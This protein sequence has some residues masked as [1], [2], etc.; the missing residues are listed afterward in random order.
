MVLLATTGMRPARGELPTSR[1]PSQ[2]LAQEL[3]RHLRVRG[4]PGLERRAVIHLSRAADRAGG[5]GSVVDP[6]TADRFRVVARAD[7][8]SGRGLARD[9]RARVRGARL[10][11]SMFSSTLPP[12]WTM[13]AARSS[14]G[15]GR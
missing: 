11:S 4:Q 15:P 8:A 12:P 2:A 3:L 9:G 10:T 7:D 5:H 1:L 13:S 14:F 6:R